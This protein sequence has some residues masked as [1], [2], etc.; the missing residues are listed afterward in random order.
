MADHGLT[1]RLAD[2][3]YCDRR[4]GPANRRQVM[5]SATDEGAAAAAAMRAGIEEADADLL[6][7]LDERERDAFRLGLARVASASTASP[8]PPEPE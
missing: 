6:A 8:A 2:P 4:R 5:L 7:G 1:E 3:G